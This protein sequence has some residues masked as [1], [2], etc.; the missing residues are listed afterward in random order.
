MRSETLSSPA[1]TLGVAQF[2]LPRRKRE[3]EMRATYV[4]IVILALTASAL[5]QDEEPA[6]EEPK[7]E[8]GGKKKKSAK[9]DAMQYKDPERQE[10]AEKFNYCEHDNCYELLGVEPTAGPIPIKRAYRRLAAEYHPDKCSTGDVEY[11]RQV[12]PKYANAYEIL[13]STEMRKN[14]NYVLENP[15]EFPGFY[16]KYSRPKYAPKSDLR[17][18][19]LVTVL[20][21]S[22]MQYLLKK[23]QHEQALASMKRA[24]TTR[25]QERVKDAMAALEKARPKSEPKEEPA[26]AVAA[27]KDGKPPP[28]PS[29]AKKESKQDKIEKLR[30]DAEAQVDA[31]LSELLGAAPTPY[32]SLIV[33]LFKL[34]ITAKSAAL[35][36]S[37]GGHKEP[38][39]MTRQALGMSQEEWDECAEAEQEELK[40]K[41]LWIADNL[42]E[43]EAELASS[44][45]PKSKTAK[46]KRMKRLAKKNPGGFA[47][48]D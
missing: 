32:D 47:M 37:T 39:Y 45:T 10:A 14:Y 41:E 18:V 25:Y 44:N 2:T 15:F 27:T 38:G 36:Y 22:A 5:A 20:G 21:A 34:P 17:F 35:F 29:K 42:T 40:G 12:F 9:E 24:P 31:E 6:S 30:K 8:S 43:Y 23:S 7:K 33:S 13:S 4:G 26:P 48:S 1:R 28:S 16:F 3:C 19:F 11:C 46:D